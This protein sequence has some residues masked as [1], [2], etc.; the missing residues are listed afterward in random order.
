MAFVEVV[1]PTGSLDLVQQNPTKP[2]PALPL[3]VV[4]GHTFALTTN[5]WSDAAKTT[6]DGILAFAVESTFK[7]T[8]EDGN[9]IN[10][11]TLSGGQVTIAAQVLAVTI[12]K[13]TTAAFVKGKYKYTWDLDTGTEQYHHLNGAFTVQ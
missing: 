13:G 3:F 11:S 6:A 10:A 12:P 4:Q 2:P 9:V 8:D 7:I 5:R 1:I